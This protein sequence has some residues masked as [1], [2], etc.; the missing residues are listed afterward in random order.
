MNRLWLL[1]LLITCMEMAWA[2]D[3][4]ART[5]RTNTAVTDE[6]IRQSLTNGITTDFAKAFPSKSF[7][8]HVVVDRHVSDRFNGEGIY[9]SLGLC[10]RLSDGQYQLALGSLSELIFLPPGTPSDAQR[11]EVVQMLQRM[12]SDFS[13]G[14]IQNRSRFSVAPNAKRQ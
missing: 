3:W 9:L 5:T 7:G 2:S 6:D 1:I 10:R 11:R 12:A 8:I 13:R 4:D 14:M